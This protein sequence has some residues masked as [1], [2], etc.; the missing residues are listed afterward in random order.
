MTDFRK[1]FFFFVSWDQWEL[2]PAFKA[3][4]S[5]RYST[6]IF[7]DP[8][9][10]LTNYNF[11]CLSGI[12]LFEIRWD[13]LEFL[14]RRTFFYCIFVFSRPFRNV[15]VNTLD[16]HPSYGSKNTEMKNWNIV[17]LRDIRVLYKK[18]HSVATISRL[19]E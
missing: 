4:T 15:K 13:L 11:D 5:L 6:K 2:Y 14:F 12:F 19:A 7:T 17:S 10:K 9:C 16:P 1:S 8:L 3:P 18:Q